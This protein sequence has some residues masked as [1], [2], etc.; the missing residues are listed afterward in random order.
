[1]SDAF[2]VDAQPD[3]RGGAGD[4]EPGAQLREPITRALA[5]GDLEGHLV[6]L[7]FRS[8]YHE[9]EASA[10]WSPWD[11]EIRNALADGTGPANPVRRPADVATLGARLALGLNS[12]RREEFFQ[13]AQHELARTPLPPAASIHDDERLLLGVAA[14]I[15]VA[16]PSQAKSIVAIGRPREYVAPWRLLCADLWAD[17]LAHG[18]ARL[19]A[20]TAAR[21]FMH[22]ATPAA[23]R[24]AATFSDAITVFWLATR[25]FDADWQPS[26]EQLAKLSHV[27]ADGRRSAIAGLLKG[28]ALSVLDA[29][30]LTDALTA[31]PEGPLQRR[32][33]LDGI[34]AVVDAFPNSA[35]V[36]KNRKRQRP[37]L[38]INDEYDVQD[39]FWTLALVVVRDLVPE[40]PTA[41]VAGRSSRLDFTSK[42]ARL[43]VELKHVR[44]PRHAVTVREEILLDERTYQEHPYVDT[45]VVLVH[46]PSAHIPLNERH[47]FERDLSTQVTVGGRTVAYRVYVR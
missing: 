42:S 17:S 3:C 24:P 46:D 4:I 30:Y 35:A 22:L 23:T 47:T 26:D 2:L 37:S 43:G 20:D 9:V 6:A 29:A 21:A 40:D 32:S 39:L 44:D 36:L 45:V 11:H 8:A 14:G 19:S 27:L 7:I 10:V 41:K 25:L 38:P 16:A 1:M 15:G 12:D 31:S 33:L 5:A 34:V 28:C 18:S 13:A